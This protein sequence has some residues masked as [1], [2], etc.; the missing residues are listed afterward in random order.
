MLKV[1][2]FVFMRNWNKKVE[3]EEEEINRKKGYIEGVIL[4]GMEWGGILPFRYKV[5]W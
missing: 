2:A 5:N 4:K 3:K 1:C